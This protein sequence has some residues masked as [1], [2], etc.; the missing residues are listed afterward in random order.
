MPKLTIYDMSETELD[1][2]KKQIF[3]ARQSNGHY[4]EFFEVEYSV[5]LLVDRHYLERVGRTLDAIKGTRDIAMMSES[6]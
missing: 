1:Y 3:L 5:D 2:F 4:P 6:M